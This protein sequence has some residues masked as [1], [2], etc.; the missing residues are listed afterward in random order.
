M[1]GSRYDANNYI[2]SL[3]SSTTT[4]TTTS[5]SSPSTNK[6]IINDNGKTK[7]ANDNNTSSTNIQINNNNNTNNNNNNNKSKSSNLAQQNSS[8]SNKLLMNTSSTSLSSS[9][10]LL[11]ANKNSNTTQL[12]LSATTPTKS[13]SKVSS[14][15]NA[16]A[17]ASNTSNNSLSKIPIQSSNVLGIKNKLLCDLTRSIQLVQK[18]YLE[19]DVKSLTNSDYHVHELCQQF[20][21]IFL[22]GLKTADEGYWKFV[23]EFTHRNVIG[24][25]NGLLN[26]STNF[27]RGR[28]WLY[29]ALNDNLMESYLKCI[30]ENK[31]LV[32]RFYKKEASLIADEQAIS[33]LVTLVAGLEN[34][35]FK[36]HNDVP[37]LDH[38]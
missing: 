4:T 12:N 24:D 27:G 15:N 37:Y 1:F 8:S 2:L 17:S 19:K 7:L 29:H 36:L 31:K 28:A 10:S 16:N 33:V 11:M 34:I 26:I 3:S 21:T 9:S 18:Y 25:L 38:S 32:V 30:L 35:E 5:S 20:D 23:L 13:A 14:S 22:Y 6:N